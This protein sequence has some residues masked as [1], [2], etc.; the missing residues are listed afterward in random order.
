MYEDLELRDEPRS[1]INGT[2][3]R[4]YDYLNHIYTM[5]LNET[6]ELFGT[7]R[8]FINSYASNRNLEEKVHEEIFFYLFLSNS[9]IVL[10]RSSYIL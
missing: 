6:Y 3:E 2:T 5:N 7:W 1:Y 10:R 8:K 9:F 4:D